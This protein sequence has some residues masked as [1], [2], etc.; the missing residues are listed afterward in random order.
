MGEWCRAKSSADAIAALEGARVPAGPV[1]TM[2]EAIADPHVRASDIFAQVEFPGLPPAP[3]AA[4]PVKLHSTPGTV[5]R[6]PPTLGEHT[7]EILRELGYSV[8]EAAARVI[9]TGDPVVVSY[10]LAEDS[11]WGLGIGCSGAVDI[12]IERIG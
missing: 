1:Y 6:R 5:R 4:T 8:A 11:V 10:D 3:I 9:A 2:Q 12:R 7:S